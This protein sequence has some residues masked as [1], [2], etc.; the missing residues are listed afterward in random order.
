MLLTVFPHY[1][2]VLLTVFSH[3]QAV[4]L[5]ASDIIFIDRL[6]GPVTGK[7]IL[8]LLEGME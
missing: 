1:Q 7:L 3:Y 5:T 2:A 6:T 4:Q 8:T